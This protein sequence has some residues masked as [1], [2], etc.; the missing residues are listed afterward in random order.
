[1]TPLSAT[2]AVGDRARAVELMTFIHET[3]PAIGLPIR[4]RPAEVRR[5]V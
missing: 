3:Y 5:A 1:M 4:V 2:A